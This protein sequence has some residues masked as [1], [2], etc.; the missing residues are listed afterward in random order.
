MKLGNILFCN[1]FHFVGF[2]VLEFDFIQL[3]SP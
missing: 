2:A 1:V 3:V